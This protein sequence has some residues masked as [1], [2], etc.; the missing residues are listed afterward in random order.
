MLFFVFSWWLSINPAKLVDRIGKVLTPALLL[1][2]LA[3][4]V[5]SLITPMGVPQPPLPAYATATT[6]LA[7]GAIDGYNT[8]DAIA[9]FV[10]AILVIE[11]VKE[12]GA[13]T[14][15]EITQSRRPGRIAARF[16]LRL[17]RLSR[18]P[19]RTGHFHAGNGRSCSFYECS[20]SLRLW[21]RSAAG[22]H[23]TPGMSFHFNRSDYVLCSVLPSA[24][25]Q[26]EL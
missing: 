10:F 4:I 15:E 12:D 13:T 6:A 24:H 3:L 18:C 5:K 20:D 2:I 26:D 23:R 25:R 17:C 9:A 19:V 21:R 14:K 7:Q 8:L 22:S 11:F 16:R 1:T